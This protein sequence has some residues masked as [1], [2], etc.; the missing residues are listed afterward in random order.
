MAQHVPKR[1][2]KEVI[3]ADATSKWGALNDDI[4]GG[5]SES[6]ASVIDNVIIWEGECE[7]VINNVVIRG[8]GA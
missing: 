5:T 8:L 3:I 4:M 2:A 6:S 1:E 7:N